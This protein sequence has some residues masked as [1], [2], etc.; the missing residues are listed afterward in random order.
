MIEQFLLGGAVNALLVTVVAFLLSRF[1][2]E[3]YGRALPAILLIVAGGTYVGF[4]VAGTPDGVWPLA[5][6]AQALV[7]GILAL[8]GL[9]GSPYWLV[10]A[11]AVHPLWDVL[12]HYF[13]AGREFA[14][15][16]WAISCVS[17]D[18]II[19]GYLVVAHR[20][21]L[22]A[23]TPRSDADRNVSAVVG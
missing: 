7:L 9:R 13:G 10:G 17:F 18:L 3:I 5:E 23:R 22:A 14:P 15:A 2:G 12:L 11:W 1:V 20:F 19:A 21:S 16:A 8:L 4:A 6:I